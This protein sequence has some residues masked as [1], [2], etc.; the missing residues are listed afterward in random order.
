MRRL[1][2]AAFVLANLLRPLI[3]F[4]HDTQPHTAEEAFNE[5]LLLAIEGLI[6]GAIRPFL[7]PAHLLGCIAIGVIGA[8]WGGKAIVRNLLLLTG[9]TWVGY[10]LASGGLTLP[11]AELSVIGA[12]L[13]FGWVIP[14]VKRAQTSVILLLI[15]AFALFHGAVF[16]NFSAFSQPV[17]FA[18]G[19]TAIDLLLYL[20]GIALG[21][22]MR[23]DRRTITPYVVGAGMLVGGVILLIN[24]PL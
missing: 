7:H 14:I 17:A 1:L 15:A 6:N 24:F 18:I 10:T 2:I 3:A 5:S 8:Q 23:R 21:K 13:L 11:F 9:M 16:G 19:L 20:G 12:V 22:L 4:A